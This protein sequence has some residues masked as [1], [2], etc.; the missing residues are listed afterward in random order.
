VAL[1]EALQTVS[2]DRLTSMLQAHWSGHTLLESAWRR[3]FVWERGYLILDDTVVPKP[4]AT[5]IEGLAWVYS[6]Q[7][8]QPVS[9]FSLGLLIWTNGMLRS[10]L[11]VRLWRRGGP[12]KIALA[13]ERLSDV[14][15]H[16]HGRPDDVLF[17][18]W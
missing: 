4:F 5:A 16:L 2:H 14:R 9:G 15:H 13:L 7:A 3:V 11:G 17:D 12:S 8:R 18:A 6:S 10:P 1:A